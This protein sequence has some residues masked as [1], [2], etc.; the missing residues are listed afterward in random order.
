MT[1]SA[2]GRLCCRSPQ[3]LG[4]KFPAAKCIGFLAHAFVKDLLQLLSAS[5]DPSRKVIIP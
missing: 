3:S 1:M 5:L 4:D 2:T